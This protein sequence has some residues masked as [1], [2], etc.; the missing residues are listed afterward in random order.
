MRDCILLSAA[1]LNICSACS[2]E[3]QAKSTAELPY[4]LPSRGRSQ[5][6]L[7]TVGVWPLSSG[8]EDGAP[9]FAAKTRKKPY[10]IPMT[11]S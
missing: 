5:R 9:N 7:M 10:F 3:M 6:P 4:K 11:L 8:E 1:V 2:T